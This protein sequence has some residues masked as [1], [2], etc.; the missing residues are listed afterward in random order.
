MAKVFLENVRI[1]FANGLF[2][3]RAVGD[4][5]PSYSA[6]FLIDYNDKKNLDK[7]RAAMEA[8]AKEKWGEKGKQVYNALEKTDK[9]ALH[10]GATKPEYDGY[11]GVFFINGRSKMGPNTKQGFSVFDRNKNRI[12]KEEGLIY[13]GCFVNASLEVWAQDRK[14][15]AGKRINAQLKG[16]QF[17]RDGDSFSGT[18][19]AGED[20]FP[21][22]EETG[23]ENAADG[24]VNPLDC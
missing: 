9:L 1:T 10:D 24:D 2:E 7:V 16:V 12:G 11:E 13:S 19:A 4:S 14:D 3:K 17:V 5:E 8:V 20:D 22:L 18:S 23:E 21:D 6:G 15:E